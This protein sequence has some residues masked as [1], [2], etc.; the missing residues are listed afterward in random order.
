MIPEMQEKARDALALMH[1][2]VRNMR[3]YPPAGAMAVL[4]VDR[5]YQTLAD[6]LASERKLIFT[7]SGKTILLC[8]EPLSPPARQMAQHGALLETLIRFGIRSITL[9]K[10]LGRDELAAYL[11][12]IAGDPERVK[13]E[14]GLPRLLAEKDLHHILIDQK[15]HVA[16]AGNG[17]RRMSAGP[18]M[19][20]DPVVRDIIWAFPKLRGN[21]E[22]ARKTAGDPERLFDLFRSAAAPGPALD[23][24]EDS[25]RPERLMHM[26]RVLD[27][28]SAGMGREEREGLCR[29]IGATI[30]GMAPETVSRVL[31][32]E[33]ESL[34]GGALLQQIVSEL[35]DIRFSVIN[36]KL[37]SR[38]Y[39]GAPSGPD[40]DAGEVSGFAEASWAR[41]LSGLKQA[42]AAI[43]NGA[44]DALLDRLPTEALPECSARLAEDDP[45]ALRAI[46]V[47]LSSRLRDGRE[48]V[49]ARA[50]EAMAGILEGLPREH[51]E[52]L[53]EEIADRLAEWIHAEAEPG[54][55]YEK[56]CT[57]LKDR[58][59]NLAHL[60]RYEKA[61]PMVDVFARIRAGF[62][63]KNVMAQKIA[64]G[65]IRDLASESL[66]G[67]L[68]AEFYG[69]RDGKRAASGRMLCRLGEGP[70]NRLLD[71][72]RVQG[73]S[74]KRV[75]ILQ[76]LGEVG[77]MV[78]PLIRERIREGGAW[79]YLR[80][81]AYL[82]GRAG[83][84]GEAGELRPLLL[85]EDLRVRREALRSVHRIGGSGRG[86]LLLSVLP[87]AEDSARIDIVEML[88]RLKCD[89]A[90]VPLLELLRDR[91]FIASPSRADLEEAICVALGRIGSPGAV[92]ALAEIRES[93]RFLGVQPY[94]EKV[95]VA[96][97]RAL[98]SI[99]SRAA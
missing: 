19:P 53:V 10:G 56:I 3:L 37:L 70:L 79:Y 69:G 91:P 57:I 41:R 1:A 51:R 85:H 45:D 29:R 21:P 6:V 94:Y 90:V 42:I 20:V 13:S 62:P 22:Q 89:D 54:P 40:P 59:V 64:A 55:A 49:R 87:A 67:G 75:R 38:G 84:E 15:V 34:F 7:V 25:R 43:P 68:F 46:V 58:V 27:R 30:S 92:R 82:L 52:A 9:E 97:S 99:R 32:G 86:P 61:V 77:P 23:G 95:I 83:G 11:E 28:A 98:A 14:G 2:A 80:N 35:D 93:G 50:S 81:L 26:I 88:G 31:S 17:D 65:I 8:G 74:D 16:P 76:V 39:Q 72:L 60:G 66:L 71:L 96:A 18:D 5:L 4:A 48:E 33:I 36:E 78:M 47:R 63:A 12:I 73:E 24:E 44:D